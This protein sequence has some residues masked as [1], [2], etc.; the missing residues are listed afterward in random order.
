MYVYTETV[1]VI[2][3]GV[4]TVEVSAMELLCIAQCAILG[5]FKRQDDSEAFD[6]LHLSQSNVELTSS[7][8]V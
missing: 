6:K 7:N 8:F 4:N 2:A 5:N 1:G 3:V